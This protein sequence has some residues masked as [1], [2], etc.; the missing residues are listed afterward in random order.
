M[1]NV[2]TRNRKKTNFDVVTNAE[3][4]QDMI[5]LYIMDES[6]VPKKWRFMIGK[7]VIEKIDELNDNVIAANSIYAM[8]EEDL[9]RRKAYQQRAI[10]NGYQLHRKLARLIRC[11]PT[12]TASSLEET[13]NLL[14]E[15]IDDLKGWK[16]NDKIRK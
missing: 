6:K 2:Y 5:T 10:S 3:K 7:G 15:E 8:N 11:V 14:T 1:S 9:A 16:K 4:L 12:A 13:L